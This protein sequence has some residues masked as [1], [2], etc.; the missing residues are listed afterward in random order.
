MKLLLRRFGILFVI[1]GV[2]ILAFSEFK[3][4]ENNSLLIWS[5]ILIVG[6]LVIY[7][8]LNNIIE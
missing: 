1:I 6:G 8:I 3:Q 2:I 5:G 7:I 4:L